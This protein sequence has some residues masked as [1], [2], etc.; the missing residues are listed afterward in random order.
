MSQWGVQMVIGKLIA[1]DM[2]RQR[3]ENR[4]HET[5]AK[6]CELGIDLSDTEV[7]A[8]LDMDRHLWAVLA[9]RIDRRLRLH[10]FIRSSRLAAHGASGVLTPRQ[11]EVLRGVFEGH[12]NKRIAIRIGVS[13]SA[14]KGTLQQLF[15]KMGVRTRA[16]L[17][18]VVIEGTPVAPLDAARTAM[19]PTRTK[20]RA[21]K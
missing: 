9:G 16:Q 12:S 4:G 13:E 11:R 18:I 7:A 1:D 5:L 15:R 17:V 10:R 20:E 3:F 8:F 2:F 14:I 6:L 21:V 19:S